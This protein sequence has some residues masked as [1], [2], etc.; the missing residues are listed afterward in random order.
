M[1]YFAPV[2]Y[3]RS[4]KRLKLKQWIATVGPFMKDAYVGLGLRGKFFLI[5]NKYII[6]MSAYTSNVVIHESLFSKQL[7]ENEYRYPSEN[8][9]LI[10]W[11]RQFFHF[12]R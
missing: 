2:I 12:F 7:F 1:F 5:V 8:Q 4:L 10:E 6:K 3:P 9:F 11:E